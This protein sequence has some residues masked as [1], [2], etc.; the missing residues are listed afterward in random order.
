MGIS[1]KDRLFVRFREKREGNS[2]A[3]QYEALNLRQ[4]EGVNPD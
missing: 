3:L 2:V 4:S 1:F